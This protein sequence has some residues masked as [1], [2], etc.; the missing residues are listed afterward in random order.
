RGDTMSVL[1]HEV[2]HAADRGGF[3][4]T[5]GSLKNLI[6]EKNNDQVVKQIEALA[7]QNTPIGR[8]TA[9]M[10]EQVRR[11]YD[12]ATLNEEIPA[13]FINLAMA[14]RTGPGRNIISA[15]RTRYKE[16]TGNND[17]NLNDVKY[18]ADQLVREA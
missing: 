14:E 17:L 10:L 1:S 11:D 8:R 6:G 7:K 2:K 12:E 3:T 9:E 5:R 18:L 15:L 16:L 4:P 13:N